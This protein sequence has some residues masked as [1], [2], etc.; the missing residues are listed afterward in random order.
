MRIIAGRDL[1]DARG[2]PDGSDRPPAGFQ[3]AKDRYVVQLDPAGAD[4][5][6]EVVKHLAL[7]PANLTHTVSPREGPLPF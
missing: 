3:R 1:T 7:K 6:E 4:P 2:P 5:S